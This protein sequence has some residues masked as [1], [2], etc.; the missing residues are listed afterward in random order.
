MGGCVVRFAVPTDVPHRRE[1]VVV[2]DAAGDVLA[3]GPVPTAGD[4][5]ILHVLWQQ[6]PGRG[7]PGAGVGGGVSP[8]L[9]RACGGRAAALFVGCAAATATQGRQPSATGTTRPHPCA[10][11]SGVHRRRLCAGGRAAGAVAA[12]C[13]ARRVCC[14]QHRVAAR[15]CH[16]HR[17]QAGSP[18]HLRRGVGVRPCRTTPCVRPAQALAA[19][20]ET[21]Q[22][23]GGA[24]GGGGQRHERWRRRRPGHEFRG[25]RCGG[26]VELGRVWGVVCAAPRAACRVLLGFGH[27]CV[28]LPGQRQNGTT[29]TTVWQRRAGVPKPHAGGPTRRPNTGA[30]RLGQSGASIA[31]RLSD[32]QPAAQPQ[33]AGS[34]LPSHRPRPGANQVGWPTVKMVL[35]GYIVLREG[36]LVFVCIF[37]TLCVNVGLEKMNAGGR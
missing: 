17:R 6:P 5:A 11:V 25:C 36:M 3:P 30:R 4:T 14:H 12:V 7:V 28:V 31:R 24:A 18:V 35:T 10:R 37:K 21:V 26:W 15:D 27:G 20:R 22:L 1:Y 13:R 33:C 19:S 23:G 9:P 16:P 29:R 8:G 32:P 2:R 34:Q